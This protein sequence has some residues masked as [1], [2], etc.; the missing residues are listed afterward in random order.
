MPVVPWFSRDQI[1][2]FKRLDDTRMTIPVW[3]ELPCYTTMIQECVAACYKEKKFFSVT[4]SLDGTKCLLYDQDPADDDITEKS[5]A[6]MSIYIKGE[7]L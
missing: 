6:N 7:E 5:D 4:Q 1:E 2:S 3:L